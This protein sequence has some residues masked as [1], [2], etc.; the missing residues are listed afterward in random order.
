[1]TRW[2][3]MFV[4][5]YLDTPEW[6]AKLVST[7]SFSNVCSADRLGAAGLPVLQ[8]WLISSA[9]PVV[10]RAAEQSPI[11]IGTY[12]LIFSWSS[13]LV[14]FLVEVY[15]RWGRF[16][17]TWWPYY[18]NR[19]TETCS[20]G[21]QA[22]SSHILIMVNWHLSKQGLRWPVLRDHVADT[23][24]EVIEVACFFKFFF[25]VDRCL[26]I[27]FWLDRKLQAGFMEA[28]TPLLFLV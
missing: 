24:L 10:Q 13:S 15:A 7:L 14:V 23:D 20:H 26:A 5:A 17:A 28:E 1:M 9:A 25:Y 27:E 18:S 19:S 11:L 16:H 2:T 21:L 4:T 6:I 3:D 8:R 22:V 12:D